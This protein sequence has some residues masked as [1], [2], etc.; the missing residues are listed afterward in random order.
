[1]GTIIRP[2]TKAW[3]T[4]DA[5]GYAFHQLLH[6]QFDRHI[7]MNAELTHFISASMFNFFVSNVHQALS[8]MYDY[9]TTHHFQIF[10][11]IKIRK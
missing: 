6:G 10:I 3:L 8:Y 9:N 7:A 1:M 2:Y 11:I 4:V 5:K